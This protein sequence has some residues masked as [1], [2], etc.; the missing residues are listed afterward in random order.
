MLAA[1]AATPER[2]DMPP[3]GRCRH[4]TGGTHVRVSYRGVINRSAIMRRSRQ[5][6]ALRSRRALLVGAVLGTFAVPGA[7]SAQDLARDAYEPNDS[8][9]TATALEPKTYYV[10]TIAGQG[11][12]DWFTITT[13]APAWSA[14][15]DGADAKRIAISGERQSGGCGEAAL[16]ITAYSADGRVVTSGIVA[17]GATSAPVD[18][19]GEPDT[20]YD[21]RVDTQGEPACAQSV[22]YAISADPYTRPPQAVGSAPPK[23]KPNAG[24]CAV[25][26]RTATAVKNRI[27]RARKLP[28][29]KRAKRLKSLTRKLAT[30]LRLKRAYC[31][32]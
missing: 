13:A 14:L 9:A 6:G 28:K 31:K 32:T 25:H 21:L 17:P 7:S 11:D 30:E 20:R 24:E 23:I 8:A 4:P 12:P 22:R 27:K 2:G 15:L 5:R 1:N 18:L 29:A 16:R 10:G 26:G 3:P 19:P